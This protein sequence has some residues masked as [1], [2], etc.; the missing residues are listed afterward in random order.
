MH[1][2]VY[3]WC[4]DWYDEKYY[5]RSPSKD[6]VGASSGSYRVSRGGSWFSSA[7]YCRSAYRGNGAPDSRYGYY[8]F[9][10]VC[11]AGHQ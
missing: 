11:S 7:A 3:E 10:L 4:Q 6:P 5:S 9:R 2:N 8:G 1:G